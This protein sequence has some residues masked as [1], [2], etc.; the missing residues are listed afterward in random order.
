MTSGT[1][2]E[3]FCKL[4]RDEQIQLVEELWNRIAE[5][6]E[7]LPLSEAQKDELR[8]RKAN[9]QDSP[10]AGV[11]WPDLKSRLLNSE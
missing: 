7:P 8:Q 6:P 2:V 5:S 4:D 1:L 9:H 10:D 11:S 3:E